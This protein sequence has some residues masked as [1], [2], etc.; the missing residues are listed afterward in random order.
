V[1]R[2]ALGIF[3]VLCVAGYLSVAVSAAAQ[4][5]QAEDWQPVSARDTARHAIHF[6]AV[7]LVDPAHGWVGG[8]TYIPPGSA[9]FEDTAI[10]GRTDSG[11]ETWQYST[12]H[13]AGDHSVGWN[14]LTVTAL[15]FVN[16]THGWATLDDGTILASTDGGA[17]WAMQAEG[18]FEN[19]DNNWGYADLAMADTTHGVAVGGWVGFIGVVYPRIA[20]TE[21]GR[22]WKEADVP[23]VAGASLESVSMVDATHGWAVGSAGAD[24]MPL[25][26]VTTDGGATWIRQTGGLR[27]GGLAL[28]G[29]CFVDRQHGWAV[30]DSGTI[31][32]TADGGASW[33]SQPSGVSVA[34][35]DVT[36][37]GAGVG[38]AVGEKGTGLVTRQAGKPWVAEESG[39]TTTLRAVASADG[40]VWAVGDEGVIV[41]G[42]VPA[43]EP[44]GSGFG[45]IG[46]SPYRTAIEALAVAGVVEG[47][48]DGT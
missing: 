48:T 28:H 42:T 3:V 29:V 33:W 13:E 4:P 2:I 45:D 31:Y 15:D 19:R 21:N 41:T 32:V 36:F 6:H 8:I 16:G 5:A 23:R 11:G 1:R 40:A 44:G 10:I 17:R 12:S 18:S 39:A 34:L 35:L 30:G 38:W 22:E 24:K 7:D 20:Y 46:S 26:L 27:A 43:P 14:F 37:A 9:G 25:V 47:F